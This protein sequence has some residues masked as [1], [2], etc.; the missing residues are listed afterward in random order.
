MK[1][2]NFM[3]K[4]IF[5]YEPGTDNI[6]FF[7]E[8]SN[9]INPEIDRQRYLE[10]ASDYKIIFELLINELIGKTRRVK[11]IPVY[12]VQE[13]DKYDLL[14]TTADGQT[15]GTS[16]WVNG[17]GG[18]VWTISINGKSE[19]ISIKNWNKIFNFIKDNI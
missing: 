2:R 8:I 9:Y 1:Y 12:Q 4:Q 6:D 13:I 18:V 17:A 7:A 19:S 3:I 5:G 16:S 10:Y 15:V 11:A 14:F